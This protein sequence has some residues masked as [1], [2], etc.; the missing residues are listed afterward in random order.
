MSLSDVFFDRSKDISLL[1]EKSEA[2]WARRFSE[3][4]KFF[5]SFCFLVNE[6]FCSRFRDHSRGD[7]SFPDFIT[8][9][10]LTTVS[11]EIGKGPLFRPRGEYYEENNYVIGLTYW[12]ISHD[13][14][15]K[16]EAENFVKERLSFVEVFFRFIEEFVREDLAR[17]PSSNIYQDKVSAVENWVSEINSR[18]LKGGI[19]FQYRDGFLLPS[20]DKLIS[21]KVE[22]P[23]WDIIAYPKWNQTVQ[24]MMKAVDRKISDPATA[25]NEAQLALESVLNEIF[26]KKGGSI[27]AKTSNLLKKKIISKHEK[28]MIDEFF[29][30]VRHKSSHAKSASEPGFPVRRNYEEAEWII[31]F[32]MY[33][34]RRI[35]V[36]TKSEPQKSALRE[37]MINLIRK[38]W[39]SE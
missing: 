30:R 17:F 38:P 28:S 16:E 23:F 31:G 6:D 10:V 3:Y 13:K 35:I 22:E 1:D 19:P 7:M 20:G 8:R 11:R 9:K 14:M 18:L 33:T 2:D 27:P 24:H 12:M 15:S 34:I 36:G 5:N 26:G 4:C 32:S 39:S 21:E 37:K 25:A 29:S